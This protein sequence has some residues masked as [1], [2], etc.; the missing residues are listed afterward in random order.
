[1]A[2]K[3]MLVSEIAEKY[4]RSR[5]TII[6]WLHIY[7]IKKKKQKNRWLILHDEVFVQVVSDPK[8]AP[9]IKLETVEVISDSQIKAQTC[10]Y[11]RSNNWKR[12]R[13]Y[14]LKSG[15]FRYRVDCRDCLECFALK[16]PSPL[17]E[18][19]PIYGRDKPVK[20]SYRRELGPREVDN[21]ETIL[22]DQREFILD[23]I[24]RGLSEEK[25]LGVFGPAAK[26]TA[27]SLYQEC[28]DDIRKS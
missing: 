4:G 13:G 5:T 18:L 20:I 26:Q 12:T 15:Q 7:D 8:H 11:C 19:V 6:N 28:I 1:M 3:W 17:A 2:D 21:P 27:K 22:R 14:K 25:I 16:V 9:Q 10:I 23:F 24:K